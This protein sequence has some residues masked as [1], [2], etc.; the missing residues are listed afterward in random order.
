MAA[1]KAIG[2][3]RDFFEEQKKDGKRRGFIDD[4]A[5]IE[6]IAN[7][8]N[9]AIAEAKR[10]KVTITVAQGDTI[11]KISPDGTKRAVGQVAAEVRLTK[12]R[13]SWQ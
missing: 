3:L 13:F 10:R 8:P 5:A 1:K 9:P 2:I 12:R 7:A 4:E 11:Y 6:M